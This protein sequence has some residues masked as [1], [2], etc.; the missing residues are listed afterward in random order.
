MHTLISSEVHVL[1]TDRVLVIRVQLVSSSSSPLHS[2]GRRGPYGPNCIMRELHDLV[3]LPEL[4]ASRHELGIPDGL[5]WPLPEERFA[6][7]LWALSSRHSD[8][9]VGFSNDSHT[10]ATTSLERR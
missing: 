9:I 5:G 6:P 10:Q 1:S 7:T 8:K 3:V 4:A 2:E